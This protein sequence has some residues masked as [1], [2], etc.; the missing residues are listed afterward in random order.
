VEWYQLRVVLLPNG[1]TVFI[2]P[3]SNRI[4]IINPWTFLTDLLMFHAVAYTLRIC[5]VETKI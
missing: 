1:L 3:S 4:K 2:I 5:H